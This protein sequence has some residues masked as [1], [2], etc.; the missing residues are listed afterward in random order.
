[1]LVK[2]YFAGNTVGEAYLKSVAWPAQGVLVGDP[3]ARPFGT[4]A[5]LVN[6]NLRITTTSLEPGTTHRLYAAPSS[7]GIHA[8]R[9][10]F[11]AEE[12][13]RNDQRRKNEL[14]GL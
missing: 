8:G 11:R 5:T 10:G 4:K 2:N 12:S 13:I 6:G 3:M 9:D 7:T 14:A 1:V